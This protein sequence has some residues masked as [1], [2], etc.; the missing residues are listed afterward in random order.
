VIAYRAFQTWR[1]GDR[2][3]AW[4]A[5]WPAAGFIAIGST[6]YVAN[7]LRF[8]KAQ[9]AAP[10]GRSTVHVSVPY[11]TFLR[12]FLD[13]M[14]RTFWGLPA[15]RLGIGLPWW[16]SHAL[17]VVALLAIPLAFWV[18]PRLRRP[19]FALLVLCALNFAVYLPRARRANRVHVPGQTTWFAIHG[20]YLYALLVPLAIFFAVAYAGLVVRIFR[21]GVVWLA[22]A[23]IGVGCAT[24]VTTGIMMLTDYWQRNG[25]PLSKHLDAMLAWSPLPTL[26]TLALL[27]SPF[28]VMLLGLWYV[29]GLYRARV[30]GSGRQPDGAAVLAPAGP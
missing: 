15:R 9:P 21:R 19:L 8:H 13:Q 20:R 14:S 17:S 3:R 12:H 2:S 24:H 10:K 27:V 23:V 26:L 4:R 1:S 16:A 6:W 29:A 5:A 7:V 18:A 30:A 25:G 22:V 28:V 11:V